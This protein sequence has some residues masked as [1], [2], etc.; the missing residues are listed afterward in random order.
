MLGLEAEDDDANHAAS[1][2]TPPQA[3]TNEPEK[4]LNITNKTTGQ[5]TPEWNNILKGI[6]DGKVKSV[7]DVRKYFKVSKEA[8]QTIE[9]ALKNG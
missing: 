7:A 9:E 5:P 2:K 8:A 1:A 3:Q 4:W 6:A